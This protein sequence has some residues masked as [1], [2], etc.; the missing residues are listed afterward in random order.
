MA[1]TLSQMSKMLAWTAEGAGLKVDRGG[2]GGA[3]I[4]QKVWT[5]FMDD[6]YYKRVRENLGRHF[7]VFLVAN[8]KFLQKLNY[9]L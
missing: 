2:G 1:T 8:H 5:S 7:R 4:A 9:L 3:K 6:P